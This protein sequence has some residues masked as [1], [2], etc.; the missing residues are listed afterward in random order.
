MGEPWLNL[1]KR[2]VLALPT[3]PPEPIQ[4]ISVRDMNRKE[5]NAYVLPK[6]KNT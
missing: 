1:N 5:Q 4:I 6:E 2:R 3:I